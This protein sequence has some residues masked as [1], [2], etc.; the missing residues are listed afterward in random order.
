M[1]VKI[2]AET[3]ALRAAFDELSRGLESPDTLERFPKGLLDRLQGFVNDGRIIDHSKIFNLANK[4]AGG[5]G[6]VIVS[7]EPGTLIKDSIAALR[8]LQGRGAQV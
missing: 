7:M 4:R 2:Y 1:E 5:A 3:E 6:E 8:A